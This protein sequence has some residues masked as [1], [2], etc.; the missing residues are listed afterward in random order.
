MCPAG[1]AWG[2]KASRLKDTNS[3]HTSMPVQPTAAPLHALWPPEK[4]GRPLAACPLPPH[5]LQGTGALYPQTTPASCTCCLRAGLLKI[6]NLLWLK[7]NTTHR[8]TAGLA[9]T[10]SGMRH[11][12]CEDN[13]CLDLQ[14]GPV[15]EA[16][17][18]L[19]EGPLVPRELCPEDPQPGLLQMPARGLLRCLRRPTRRSQDCVCT[20]AS[21]I[22]PFFPS[23]LNIHE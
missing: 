23:N 17:L 21:H 10:S 20:E 5:H 3:K 16:H 13:A 2:E 8:C 14:V 15:Q 6:V 12:C 4:A 19:Q 7:D 18:P 11:L 22:F 1:L 9:N